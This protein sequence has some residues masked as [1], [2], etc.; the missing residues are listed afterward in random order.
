[1]SL[2]SA[3]VG[4]AWRRFFLDGPS[5][6][7]GSFLPNHIFRLAILGHGDDFVLMRGMPS[8]ECLARGRRSDLGRPRA[9]AG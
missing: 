4:S 3:K 1:M 6:R 2:S 5:F 8:A 9:G 7:S